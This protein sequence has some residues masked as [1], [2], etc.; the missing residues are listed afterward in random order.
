MKIKIAW[1]G[2]IREPAIAAL[3]Q[4]YLQR[5]GRY[6]PVEAVA[7]RDEA[8]L[9][10]MCGRAAGRGKAVGGGKSTLAWNFCVCQL[11]EGLGAGD[12]FVGRG[13]QD[14]FH[15]AVGIFLK[16]FRQVQVAEFDFLVP[17]AVVV[18]IAAGV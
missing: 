18:E 13:R 5:I 7:L 3:T 6:A 17:V 16:S 4:E 15:A 8:A 10:E 9:L 2:K 12:D 14:E 11:V 1:V